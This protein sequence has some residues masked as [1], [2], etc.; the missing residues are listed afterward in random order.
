[1]E[2]YQPKLFAGQVG[3]NILSYSA[4]SVNSALSLGT[5]NKAFL[6]MTP[7]KGNTLSV[8]L[9]YD[10]VGNGLITL[11]DSLVTGQYV[12]TYSIYG[13][14]TACSPPSITYSN[15]VPL[16]IFGSPFVPLNQV[17]SGVTTTGRFQVIN[18]FEIDN[19]NAQPVVINIKAAGTITPG[20]VTVANLF[21]TQIGGLIQPL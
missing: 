2:L 19:D 13:A 5:A 20:A 4:F 10:G 6:G 14:N 21:L 17:D 18:A 1:V 15:A 11:D 3:N 9:S 16:N 7:N 12:L 8:D